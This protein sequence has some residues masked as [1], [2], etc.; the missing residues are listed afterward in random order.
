MKKLL[1]ILL[2]AA[3]LLACAPVLAEDGA[4]SSADFGGMTFS[5]L[6]KDTTS[7]LVTLKED[8]SYAINDGGDSVSV[9]GSLIAVQTNGIAMML[10]L[11]DAYLCFTQD[12]IA[13][14]KSYAI[15]ND[16]EAMLEYLK[17]INAHFYLYDQYTLNESHINTLEADNA[18]RFVGNLNDL[19]ESDLNAFALAFAKANGIEYQD[20]YK[21]VTSTWLYFSGEV[22]VY[23]TVVNGGYLAYFAG[24]AEEEDAQ[25]ILSCLSVF[26]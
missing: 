21:T 3:L 4:P 12:Y 6:P 13:S 26:G 20:T 17:E 11:P 2:S 25:E 16:P 19:S 15:V 23:V 24:D 14:I 7:G 10:D 9:Y 22:S 5:S 8:T 1:S 18:S